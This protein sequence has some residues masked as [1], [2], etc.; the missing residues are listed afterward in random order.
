MTLD[1]VL[2]YIIPA[3]PWQGRTFQEVVN[4]TED[5]RGRKAIDFWAQTMVADGDML[6]VAIQAI[7]RRYIELTKSNHKVPAREQV[8]PPA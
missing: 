3:G 2:A 1:Q 8:A 6:K 5:E 7:A 4:T